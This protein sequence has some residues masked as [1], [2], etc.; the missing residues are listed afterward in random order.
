MIRVLIAEDHTLV[1]EGIK[2]LLSMADDIEVVGEASDGDVLFAALR[3]TACEVL[4]LDMTMPGP[5]GIEAIKRIAALPQA[6]RILVLTMHNE[7]QIA[8]RALKAGA[9]GFATK[10]SEPTMLLAAIRKV[11]AGRRYIDPALADR[12]V[13]EMGMGDARPPHETLS[14]REYQIF[15]L[16][17]S[18]VSVTE[19]GERLSISSKTVST[20]K[21]R[22]LQKLNL[23]TTADLVRY[24]FEAQLFTP[25]V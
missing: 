5:H 6:P 7:T 22:L 11:A 13:F 18:G 19:I 21:I 14:E 4:L 9:S 17:V 24:A 2:Q 3:E 12:M 15:E 23:T 20:H 8:S 25:G 16:L 1:R 10:D